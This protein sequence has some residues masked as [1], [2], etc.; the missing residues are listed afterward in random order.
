MVDV[1]SASFGS[2]TNNCF[3]ITDKAT[4]KSALVDCS[5]P[6]DKMKEFIK[7]YDLE[8]ILLTHGHFDH[9]EGV[10][11][12]NEL[13]GAKVVI[14]KE[15]EG[16]LSSEVLSLAAF[17]G[18]NQY[19]TSADII[20]KDND[21]IMLGDSEIKVLATPGHTSGSVCYMVDRNLF[22]GDTLFCC[23]LGRTDF[24]TGNPAQM[25]KSLKRLDSLEGD[26]NVYPGHDE[27]TT[28]EYERKNNIDF[29]LLI[30][31]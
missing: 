20:V 9:I 11:M 4:N 16:M 10:K 8:Y 13:T 30:N 12:I 31:I 27:L 7:G 2:M 5:E 6:S 19:N 22:T 3:I 17:S 1:K 21:V 25:V 14:S 28:L 29:R 24:P 15:D 23:S 26:Y 18:A